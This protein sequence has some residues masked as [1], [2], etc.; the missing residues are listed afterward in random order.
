MDFSSLKG[1]QRI[2]SHTAGALNVD[3]TIWDIA[4]DGNN[5]VLLAGEVRG[6]LVAPGLARM[7][8]TPAFVGG[9]DL[10][11]AKLKP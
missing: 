9:T 11:V 7:V 10:L 8:N 4:I 5:N 1:G 3:D 6:D 2:W